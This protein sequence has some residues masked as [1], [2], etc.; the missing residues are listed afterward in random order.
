MRHYCKY[1]YE[2]PSLSFRYVTVEG[3]IVGTVF[4]SK[5]NVEE[6]ILQIEPESSYQ[7]PYYIAAPIR[8]CRP[9]K[10]LSRNKTK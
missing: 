4:N 9:I 6:F 2:S 3:E 5:T 8:N 10:K 7:E 1:E